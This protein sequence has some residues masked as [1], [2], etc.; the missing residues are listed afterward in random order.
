MS[1]L[2][3]A[4]LNG[5]YQ[6]FYRELSLYSVDKIDWIYEYAYCSTSNDRSAWALDNSDSLLDPIE[7]NWDGEQS[8]QPT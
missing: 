7:A 1:K 2:S 5:I 3:E 8:S 6:K 4:T